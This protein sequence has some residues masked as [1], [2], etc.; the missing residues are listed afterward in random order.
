MY[1]AAV[2]IVHEQAVTRPPRTPAFNHADGPAVDEDGKLTM[3]RPP[4]VIGRLDS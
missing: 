3:R 1:S 2:G 4:T